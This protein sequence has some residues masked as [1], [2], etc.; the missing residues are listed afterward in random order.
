M[1][2][3]R[4][5][6][7]RVIGVGGMASVWLAHDEELDRP[8]AVK[9]L[10]EALA[11]DRDYVARFER[12]ART[13]ASV[14]HSNLVNVFDLDAVGSRPYLVMEYVEGGTLAEAI[15]R[16]ADL[17]PERIARELLSALRA[18]HE[19]GII[20]RDVKPENVLVGIDGRMRLTDFGIAQPEDASRLTQTGQMVGT[21]RF[22]SPELRMGGDPTVRSDLYSL[23]ILLREVP[24]SQA[25]P[26]LAE[27]AAHL[28][29]VDPSERPAS[30]AET[31]AMLE[32]GPSPPVT[33]AMPA[34]EGAAEPHPDARAE[35]TAV[36]PTV[37][38]E[39]D[40]EPAPPVEPAPAAARR[41][42]VHVDSARLLVAAI[43]LVVALI[44]AVTVLDEDSPRERPLLG[45]GAK[46]NPGDVEG[47]SSARDGK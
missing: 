26:D 14:S 41:S 34:V 24:G 22:M 39:A 13:A 47:A 28:S 6:L 33:D 12:E 17:D 20:H 23:G 18:I 38:P 40:R 19:A 46:P 16:G 45:P 32:R 35:P 8:V 25:D 15:E 27:L 11:E 29:R 1:L 37:E 2:G 30:A 42:F 9:I 4:F 10:S 3:D 36:V 5:R 43:A 7:E 21:E 44:V 31:L